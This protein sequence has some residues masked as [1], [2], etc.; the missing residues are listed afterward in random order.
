MPDQSPIGDPFDGRPPTSH[1]R[2]SGQPWDASYQNG[3]APWDIGHPQPLVVRLA[4]NGAFTGSVLDAGCGTGENSL[5]IA[6]LGLPVFGVDVAKTALA[7]A[8]DKARAR[9]ID[10]HFE[11]ADA[12]HLDRLL[13][14]FDTVLDCG[15]FHSF[16]AIE[17][18]A[19]AASV[20]SVTRPDGML[21]LLC[22]SDAGP[23]TGPH[24]ISEQQ[25]RAA[26][27]PAGGWQIVTLAP[28]RVHSRFHPNGAPAWFAII[29][30]I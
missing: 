29:K 24:P 17:R 26:F 2:M 18:P 1:E 20:A 9:A 28:D 15:L 6:A 8:R 23:D 30:R 10:A 12:L 3:P 22:F 25:L 11:A 19:Y 13:R 16:D 27:T 4:A 7:L 5:H 21:Y 14:S